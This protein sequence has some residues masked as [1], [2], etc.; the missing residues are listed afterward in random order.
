QVG[1]VG[2]GEPKPR[3]SRSVGITI[4]RRGSADV[5]S[6][7]HV[8][9]TNSVGGHSRSAQ[10]L[11]GSAARAYRRRREGL[12]CLQAR[13]GQL[14]SQICG[15]YHVRARQIKVTVLGHSEPHKKRWRSPS[16]IERARDANATI[17]GSTSPGEQLSSSVAA[18]FV[19][20]A[21]M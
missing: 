2:C 18:H 12:V 15:H 4:R 14:T 5:L 6:I 13:V 7:A 20:A 19:A 17:T 1:S 10:R 16:P 9:S 8:Y 21:A 11:W 3:S